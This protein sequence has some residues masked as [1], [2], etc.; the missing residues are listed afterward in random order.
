MRILSRGF[1]L[2]KLSIGVAI[3]GIL[4]AIAAPNFLETQTRSKASPGFHLIRQRRLTIPA[5]YLNAVLPDVSTGTIGRFNVNSL[6]HGPSWTR[7]QPW[8]TQP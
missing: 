1:T 7:S 2:I 5:A 6:A 8:R 3:V 4:A